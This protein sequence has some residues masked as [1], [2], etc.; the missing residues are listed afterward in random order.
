MDKKGQMVSGVGKEIIALILVGL[1]VAVLVAYTLSIS[2]G[3]K[4]NFNET[5]E[6]ESITAIEAGETNISDSQDIWTSILPVIGAVLILGALFLIWR[7]A[8]GNM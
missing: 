2:S 5:T 1:V 4:A 3:I 8:Q 7:A 6:A